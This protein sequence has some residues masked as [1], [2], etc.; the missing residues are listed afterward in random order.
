M[1]TTLPHR[2]WELR[3][4]DGSVFDGGNDGAPHFTTEADAAAEA[5]DRAETWPDMYPPG[6]LTSAQVDTPCFTAACNECGRT[7]DSDS[8]NVMHYARFEDAAFEAREFDFHIDVQGNAWCDDCK[9]IKPHGFT[10]DPDVPGMCGRCR[11][12]ADEHDN[13]ALMIGGGS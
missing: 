6:A 8:F 12:D 3:W 9:V 5:S 2:C 7:T 4:P 11:V 13:P 1:I 10:P